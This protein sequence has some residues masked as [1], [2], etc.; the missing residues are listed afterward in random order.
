M[1]I[2]LP[3]GLRK[4]AFAL[5][6][7][8]HELARLSEIPTRRYLTFIC[9]GLAL[10]LAVRI[11]FVI[12]TPSNKLGIDGG[13]Y[14]GHAEQIAGGH[15][16]PM[17]PF[18]RKV[19]ACPP[20]ATAPGVPPPPCN[21]FVLEKS[22]QPTAYRPPGYPYFLAVTYKAVGPGSEHV[23]H[24]V[25]RLVQALLG[26]AA[27]ALM[28][29]IGWRIWGR[30]AALIAVFIGA[31]YVPLVTVGD[32]FASEALFVPLELASIAAMLKQRDEPRR[33][34]F[35][36]LCGLLA[37]LASLTRPNGVVMMLVL[38][39]GVWTL[40]PRL[41]LRSLR[42]PLAVVLT[43]LVTIAPWT[44]RNAIDLHHFVPIST[45]DGNTLA[46]TYNDSAHYDTHLPAVW[47]D[48][49]HT[50]PYPEI[51]QHQLEIPDANY[52]RLLQQA[53]LSYIG[54]HPIYPFQVAFHNTWR[55]A[56]F[57]GARR[58]RFTAWTMGLGP[59]AARLNVLA[60]WALGLVAL[61]GVFTRRFRTTP[62]IL[63]VYAGVLYASIAFVTSETPRFRS[64]LEPFIVFLAALSL[65]ELYER[66][67]TLLQST[68]RIT[69]AVRR[70]R[71]PTVARQ[72]A[73]RKHLGYLT[74]SRD[75]R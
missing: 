44:I 52:D 10:A 25:A 3:P 43:A 58:S 28:G 29:F 13:S 35:A 33:V 34:R 40:K 27:V 11:A 42:V 9:L 64:P 4:H 65:A 21:Q 55:L 74:I 68:G 41:S 8:R 24:T 7:R 14:N 2:K 61:F 20:T 56:D 70:A 15:G 51:T 49:S 71:R 72:V 17:V 67:Q 32:S 54:H 47:H 66:R 5:I 59:H 12:A 16:Y 26:T 60:F 46:G 53:A 62:K 48:P 23:Q 75:P 6:P 45:E 31:I 30:V 37:G 19:P 36:L 69:S 63:F 39:A 22:K 18:A 57:A 38:A 50:Y 73:G 1:S